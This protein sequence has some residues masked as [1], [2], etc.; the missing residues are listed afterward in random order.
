[1]YSTALKSGADNS[2]EEFILN[3]TPPAKELDGII[4]T[5][6]FDIKKTVGPS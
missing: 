1:M 3:G 5:V 4:R 6:E 2:S